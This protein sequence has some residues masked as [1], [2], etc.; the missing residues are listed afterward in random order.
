MPF[1]VYILANTDDDELY[2]GFT[3]NPILRLLQHNNGECSFTSTKRPWYFV[4]VIEFDS[5]TY[6]LIFEKKIKRWNKSSLQNLIKSDKN[7]A[8]LFNS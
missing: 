3:E 2:K 6:A 8:G 7:I 5:K 1:Y 4:C